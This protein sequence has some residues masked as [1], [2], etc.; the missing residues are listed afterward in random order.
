MD[1]EV[2]LNLLIVELEAKNIDVEST[3]SQGVSESYLT[4]IMSNEKIKLSDDLI[5]LYS[6]RNGSPISGS[7]KT[8]ETI[9]CGSI[10][11][12]FEYSW[13]AYKYF[14]SE[15]IFQNKAEHIPIMQ[16]G[17]GIFLCYDNCQESN[18]RGVIFEYNISNYPDIY[19]PKF[20]SLSSL[21]SGTLECFKQDVCIFNSNGFID[22]DF[23]RRKEIFGKLNP[24]I[25]YWKQDD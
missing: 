12:P 24:K 10:F 15:P 13:L 6:W 14:R 11:T 18:T 9:F 3:F 7:K 5:K 20:E 17:G 4:G 2:I 19:L 8:D 1:L 22:V 16:D 25:E 21:I 23:Q